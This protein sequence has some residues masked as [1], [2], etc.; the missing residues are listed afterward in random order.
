MF[1]C[2]I[3]P[4]A[5]L[6][7]QDNSIN[8]NI[9]TITGLEFSLVD[10]ESI[11]NY[12]GF[13][14]ETSLILT[15]VHRILLGQCSNTLRQ[16]NN[17]DVKYQVSTINHLHSHHSWF[18]ST[19]SG[20]RLEWTKQTLNFRK[21]QSIVHTTGQYRWQTPLFLVDWPI[22]WLNINESVITSS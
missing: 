19:R 4:I 6:L 16:N 17:V 5:K 9:N 18:P 13:S 22:I 1:F 12:W 21:S 14:T 20:L 10:R 11:G 3:I 8:F 2:T 7:R 15:L